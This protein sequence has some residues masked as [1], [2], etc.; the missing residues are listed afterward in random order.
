MKLRGGYGKWIVRRAMTARIPE[1]IRTARLKKGFDVQVSRWI[2]EGLGDF[3]RKLLRER[4]SRICRRLMPH[5]KI[6]LAFSNKCL[7]TRP[8]AF[9]EA[10]TLLWL[11]NSVGNGDL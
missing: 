10:T 11:S 9:A 6:D 2:V 5:H 8:S 4:A 3:I 1:A 7:Q